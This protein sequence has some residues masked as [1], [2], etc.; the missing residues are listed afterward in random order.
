MPQLPT[1]GW[2]RTL[3]ASKRIIRLLDSE[4][5]TVLLIAASKSHCPGK[6]YGLLAECSSLTR[7]RILKKICP[8]LASVTA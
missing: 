5:R 4:M 3:V 2:F 8:V 7:Q 1:F 6:L